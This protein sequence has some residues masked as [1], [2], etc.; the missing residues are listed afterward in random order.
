MPKNQGNAME[1]PALAP[2]GVLLA[3]HSCPREHPGARRKEPV[4]MADRAEAGM[5]AGQ[6]RQAIDG[7]SRAPCR[8]ALIDEDDIV[9]PLASLSRSGRPYF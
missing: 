9:I 7:I 6:G 4:S 3:R 1:V 2:V 5:A 8:P